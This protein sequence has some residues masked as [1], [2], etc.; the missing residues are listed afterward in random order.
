MLQLFQ[1]PFP[2]PFQQLFQPPVGVGV[3]PP[4]KPCHG[5]PQPQLLKF[6]GQKFAGVFGMQGFV[7]PPKQLGAQ[8]PKP[9]Q[10]ELVKVG[11]Q[12]KVVVID[13]P[14]NVDDRRRATQGGRAVESRD[15]DE[16]AARTS[17]LRC[18]RFCGL[19]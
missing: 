14:V 16:I 12:P 2:P 6:G 17:A 11:V 3:Q 10:F 5:E 1:P 19:G 8:P 9:K 18:T 7:Q 15:Q 4:L 13:A